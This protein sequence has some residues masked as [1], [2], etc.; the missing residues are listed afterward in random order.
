MHGWRHRVQGM[1]LVMQQQKQPAVQKRPY[2]SLFQ[3]AYVRNHL[4]DV[5]KQILL[6]SYR[7]YLRQNRP[8]Q[9]QY[10]L[11]QLQINTQLHPLHD[12]QP[13]Y[14]M[15]FLRNRNCYIS[16]KQKAS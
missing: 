14:G 11:L 16:H 1:E 6:L 4:G 5:Q 8:V 13:L 2:A 10:L 7:L 15:V 3:A 12:H 9:L